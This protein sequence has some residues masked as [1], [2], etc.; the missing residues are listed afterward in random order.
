M[1]SFFNEIIPQIQFGYTFFTIFVYYT[2]FNIIFLYREN[3]QTNI[4]FALRSFISLFIQIMFLLMITY[5]VRLTRAE[6]LNTGYL[7][8]KTNTKKKKQ[9]LKDINVFFSQEIKLIE[10]HKRIICKICKT[11]KPPRAQHCYK[12]NRC[13]MKNEGH[14]ITLGVCLHFFNNQFL[15]PFLIIKILLVGIYVILALLKSEINKIE[16][17]LIWFG[18]PILISDIYILSFSIR[19][20]FYN[21]TEI[22]RIALNKYL[23]GNISDEDVFQQGLILYKVYSKNRMLLNPY[24]LNKK[25]NI[26]QVYRKFHYLFSI[27][28]TSKI[29][30]ISF[31]V[32]YDSGNTL[33]NQADV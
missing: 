12:C 23:E 27:N 26:I 3:N 30:G 10:K 4:H 21:E 28:F 31:P 32:N 24:F 1:S 19:N 2:S 16:I 15:I 9:T 5:H 22:E 18:F 6:S 33:F 14:S 7:F 13:Y 8:N 25:K 20:L 17:I 29:N 11:F